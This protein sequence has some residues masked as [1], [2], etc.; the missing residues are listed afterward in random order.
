VRIQATANKFLDF[1]TLAKHS[2][3]NSKK[4][5]AALS[6]FIKEIENRFQDGPKK[7][8]IIW[9]ISNFI[10]S[11]FGQFA[12]IECIQLQSKI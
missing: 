8:S 9:F 1:D 4:Y 6:A 7:S 3:V 2:P 5:A 12:N 11:Q 10:F